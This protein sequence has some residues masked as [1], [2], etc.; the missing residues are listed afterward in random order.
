MFPW[1]GSSLPTM[2]LEPTA[3]PYSVQGVVFCPKRLFVPSYFLSVGSSYVAAFGLLSVSPFRID[4]SPRAR[5]SQCVGVSVPC[6]DAQEPIMGVKPGQ[7]ILWEDW[8]LGC[9]KGGRRAPGG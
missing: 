9:R 5:A 4:S 1:L 7:K 6:T 8:R 3:R 2:P